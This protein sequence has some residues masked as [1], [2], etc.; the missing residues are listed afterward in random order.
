MHVSTVTSHSIST[1]RHIRTTETMGGGGG[2]VSIYRVKPKM[3]V[4][5]FHC[6]SNAIVLSAR[7]TYKA[8]RSVTV[9]LRIDKLISDAILQ[10]GKKE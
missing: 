8:A 3:V 10:V 7:S 9:V 5:D 4:T 6:Q 2:G 1:C